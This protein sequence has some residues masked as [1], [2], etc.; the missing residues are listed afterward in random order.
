M[1][2]CLEQHGIDIL[3][4]KRTYERFLY[5]YIG[6]KTGGVVRRWN[7]VRTMRDQNIAEHSFMVAMISAEIYKRICRDI[8]SA[9]HFFRYGVEL[10]RYALYH[11]IAE[12]YTVTFRLP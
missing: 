9:G 10:Y 4:D 8:D 3:H 7:I 2:A 1:C 11:D 5:E 12:I 6:C